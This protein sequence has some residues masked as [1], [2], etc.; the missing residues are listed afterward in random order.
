MLNERALW[1]CAL[2]ALRDADGDTE[3]FLADRLDEMDLSG[4]MEGLLFWQDVARR[5]FILEGRYAPT[6]H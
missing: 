5:V 6:K 4:D 3:A 2:D 1:W